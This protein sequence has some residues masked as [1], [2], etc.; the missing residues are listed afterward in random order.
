M[1]LILGDS[2]T[3]DKTVWKISHTVAGVAQGLPLIYY[4]TI[5]YKLQGKIESAQIQELRRNNQRKGHFKST[6][7]RKAKVEKFEL[8]NAENLRNQLISEVFG[9]SDRVR[10]CGLMV[11]NHPRYQLRYTRIFTFSVSE[12]FTVC[13][14]S[15]GQ[16]HFWGTFQWAVKSHNCL[17]SKGFQRFD[18]TRLGYRHGTPKP[19]ALPAAPH[20]EIFDQDIRKHTC[21][22]IIAENER[23]VKPFGVMRK[24]KS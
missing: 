8:F 14:Q 18:F 7:R 2:Q 22:E 6:K 12:N 4:K 20:P 23:F 21:F 13:G 15:C 19:P 10:T 9:P 3:K 5:W 17:R 24:M 11:P 16:M 1:N